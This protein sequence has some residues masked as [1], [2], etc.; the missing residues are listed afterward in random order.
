[1]IMPEL[2]NRKL[3]YTAF[4]SMKQLEGRSSRVMGSNFEANLQ[5]V[6]YQVDG[7]YYSNTVPGTLW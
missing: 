2:G 6:S 5:T 4:Y 1:M 3:N 7:T